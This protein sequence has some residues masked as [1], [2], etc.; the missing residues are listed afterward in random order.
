MRASQNGME[1]RWGDSC[2]AMGIRCLAS[3]KD[4]LYL[5]AATGYGVVV[6]TFALS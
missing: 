6:I 3:C 2:D 1:I 4:D 5:T